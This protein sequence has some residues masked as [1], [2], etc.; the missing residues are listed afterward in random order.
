[1]EVQKEVLI[2][3]NQ[4]LSLGTIDHTAK[5]ASNKSSLSEVHFYQGVT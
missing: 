1:M 3:T 4:L 2:R 5:D